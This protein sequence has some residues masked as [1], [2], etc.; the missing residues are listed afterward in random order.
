[1]PPQ[2]VKQ[3]ILLLRLG[4]RKHS[5]ADSWHL[6]VTFLVARFTQAEL[7]FHLW[8]TASRCALFTRP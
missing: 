2:H 6:A 5:K 7:G 3:H 1:L 8:K 4:V